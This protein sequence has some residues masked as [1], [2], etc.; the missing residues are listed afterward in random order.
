ME[1]QEL[2]RAREGQTRAGMPGRGRRKG[3]CAVRNSC[4]VYG[5]A[6]WHCWNE[7]GGVGLSVVRDRP[8]GWKGPG[9]A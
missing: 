9:H 5:T 2:V 7:A 6:L 8:E 3:K 4:S 1:E